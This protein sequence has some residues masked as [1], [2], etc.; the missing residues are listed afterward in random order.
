MPPAYQQYRSRLET[1]VAD[2][3]R[4]VGVLGRGGMG[5]VYEAVHTG[6]GKRVALKFLEAHAE[7]DAPTRARFLRE[8]QTASLVESPHVVHVFD[9]GW[10]EDGVPFMVLE[11][12]RGE[13]LRAL[14]RREGRLPVE[15]AISIAEQSLRALIQLH[16]AGIVHRDLKPEN[17][18]LCNIEDS[19]PLV[20][21]LDFGISKVTGPQASLDTLTHEGTVL[22]TA[23]YMSPEQARGEPDTDPRSDIYALGTI[24]YEMLTGRTPYLGNVHHAV[25]VDICTRDAPDVR[26]L[27]PLVSAELAQ[28]ITRALSRDRELRFES[29]QAFLGAIVQCSPGRAGAGSIRPTRVSAPDHPGGLLHAPAPHSSDPPHEQPPSAQ[30]RS[31]RLIALV[32]LVVL[33]A[34]GLGIFAVHERFK[35]DRVRE[36]AALWHRPPANSAPLLPTVA[37][38][39]TLRSATTVQSDASSA[40]PPAP[41]PSATNAVGHHAKPERTTRAATRRKQPNPA[42]LQ[43]KTTMP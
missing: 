6:I 13:D 40:A 33:L 32:F 11:L 26:L 21:I 12:L 2:K 1:V 19:E 38:S 25:L 9:S 16:A 37:P 15:Q 43:L 24:L 10:S 20:K 18:Y 3:Y 8:A 35:N 29:A 34:A 7:S 4:I 5:T 41:M 31:G 28:V 14:L 27:A 17:V 23:Y 30:A 39:S 36:R 42:E 22:G